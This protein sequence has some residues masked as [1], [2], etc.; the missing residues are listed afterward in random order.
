LIRLK[1]SC[2]ELWA[3]KLLVIINRAR[4][5]RAISKGRENRGH[6]RKGVGM[7]RADFGKIRSM[8]TLGSFAFACITIFGCV[9]WACAKDTDQT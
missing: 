8:L 4:V 3:N 5:R 6:S 9:L 7:K 1:T 2:V